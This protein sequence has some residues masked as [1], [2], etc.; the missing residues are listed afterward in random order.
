[1]AK[2]K[3]EMPTKFP[4]WARLK[5][6]KNRTTLVIDE[7]IA[8]NKKKKKFEDGY[9]H[10]ES[11]HPNKEGTNVKGYERIF[12]NP[13]KDDKE[14]MYLK[15]VR[16]LPKQFFNPHNKKLDMPKYL[17]DRYDKNNKK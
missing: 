11:I 17:I 15:G 10:R 2:K 13:D 5:I 7:D 8:Y 16:K 12:P 6:C 14:P 4:F 9:V 3:K 1:M